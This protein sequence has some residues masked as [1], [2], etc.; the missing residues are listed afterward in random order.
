MEVFRSTPSTN[1]P[2]IRLAEVPEEVRG[3]I[4]DEMFYGSSGVLTSVAMHLLDLDFTAIYS[5]YANGWSPDAIHTLRESLLPH[6][7]L[8][9][10]KVSPQCVMEA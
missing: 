7:E 8:V 5:G 4:S 1:T 3:L 10:E 9:A 6:V 2:A